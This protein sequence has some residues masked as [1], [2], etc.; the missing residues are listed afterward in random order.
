MNMSARRIRILISSP[1]DVADEREKAKRVIAV[2][3]KRFAGRLRIEAILW[4]DLPLP[5]T[6]S[7]QEGIDVVLDDEEGI[8]VAIF[9]LWSRL[10]TPLGPKI[11]KPDD[12]QEY[13]SGTEREFDLMI[14]AFD[15]SGRQ[16][17]EVFAYV[18]Q[19]QT[20]FHNNLIGKDDDEIRQMLD[21]REL[22]K[23]FIA[24]R[25]HDPERGH[26]LS[27]YKTFPRPNDFAEKLKS[28]LKQVLDDFTENASVK[29]WEGSPF[30]GLEL[31]EE[32]HE[33]IFFGRD[34]AVCNLRLKLHEAEE[35]G[36]AFVLIVGGSGTGKSSLVRA[37]LIPSV[38]SQ[39]IDTERE[40]RTAV[41]LPSRCS[42]RPCAGL[43]SLLNSPSVLPELNLPQ[44]KLDLLVDTLETDPESVVQR[45]LDSA[46]ARASEEAGKEICLLLIVDQLEELFSHDAI[47]QMDR[48]RFLRTIRALAQSGRF[49]I[50]ATIRSDY[51]AQVLAEP[52]L[53]ELKN[54]SG[55]AIG[56]FELFPPTAAE[57]RSIITKPAELAGLTFEEDSQTGKRLDEMILEA[58][59][60]TPEAMPMLE[61]LLQ[62]LYERRSEDDVLRIDAYEE[63]GGLEGAI[64]SH[65]ESIYRQLPEEVQRI[66]PRVLS[67]LVSLAGKDTATLVRRNAERNHFS[68]EPHALTLINTFIEERLIV[69]DSG[70]VKVVHEALLRN[71]DRVRAWADEN[72]D[73]V[74]IQDRVTR[75]EKE[76]RS[77]DRSTDYFLPSGKPTADGE[78]LLAKEEFS[79]S[80]SVR[81][82]IELSS[83]YHHERSRRKLRIFQWTSI[84]FFIV[85]VLAI[86]GLFEAGRQEENARKQTSI[87]VRQSEEAEEQREI[88]VTAAGDARAAELEMET[89]LRLAENHLGKV[90]AEKA[91]S[92]ALAK[93]HNSAHLY[94][95]LA[96]SKLDREKEYETIQAVADLAMYEPIFERVTP[97]IRHKES[98]ADIAFSPDGRSLFSATRENTIHVVDLLTGQSVGE[99]KGHRDAVN[100]L[101]VSPD[102]TKLVSGSDDKEVRIWDIPN[103]RELLSL[104][105]HK[106]GVL[107][108]AFSP[109]EKVLASASDGG[110]ALAGA[111]IRLWNARTGESIA[112]LEGHQGG[113]TSIAFSPDGKTLISGSWDK[114]VRVW[115]LD[116]GEQKAELSVDGGEVMSVAYSPNGGILVA[117][118]DSILSMDTGDRIHL[119]DA[120]TLK[121]TVSLGEGTSGVTSLAFSPDEQFLLSGH[122][123]GYRGSDNSLRIWNVESGELFAVLE[124]HTNSI[125][126]VAFSPNGSTIASGSWDNTIQ[127]WDNTANRSELLWSTQTRCYQD[128]DFSPNGQWIVASSE[129]QVSFQVFDSVSGKLR[130]EFDGHSDGVTSV[131]YSPDGDQIASGSLDKTVRI[132]DAASGREERRIE[133]H[134]GHINSVCFSPDGRTVA[135]AS[136]DYYNQLKDATIRIWD[137]DSGDELFVLEGH[138]SDVSSIDFCPD[139]SRIVSGGASTYPNPTDNTIRIW[140]LR[141]PVSPLIVD[142]HSGTVKDVRYSPSGTK[143][144]SCS[145][146]DTVRLFDAETGTEVAMIGEENARVSDATF[147]PDG[148]TVIVGWNGMV[149]ILE[150]DSLHLKGTIAENMFTRTRVDSVAISPHG[151]TIA[152]GS[153]DDRLRL[154][155]YNL[156]LDKTPTTSEVEERIA[157]F[158]MALEDVNLVPLGG[159]FEESIQDQSTAFTWSI[160]HPFHWLQAA[161]TGDSKA[162]VELGLCYEKLGNRAQAELWYKRA[163]DSG[164]R[165]GRERL[166]LLDKATQ[167]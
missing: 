122:G 76:W 70:Q 164:D 82:Y 155:R 167:D 39:N 154:W 62:Q 102:G 40:W 37:G 46:L 23:A 165:Y 56:Q 107:A 42:E 85:T 12:G 113:V 28:D 123:G 71:W 159:E 105:G 153:I 5:A 81:Q 114:T 10:G 14:R 9:I 87:A 96:L 68:N 142:A 8:D 51:Y 108:V 57:L 24:E 150:A 128:V 103:Q 161:E 33:T 158:G 83:K 31:F 115:D 34:E 60:D 134:S 93:S 15:Q 27:A 143:I 49:W 65:A 125:E 66:L 44:Q 156:F 17:P 99:F 6:A 25:F 157:D 110:V 74:Q 77:E 89:Q 100:A 7:F 136:R 133:G 94:A 80:S 18:R 151:D 118:T 166:S 119:W 92:S 50:V 129:T 4:E 38:L 36:S 1:G 132:W 29:S 72:R 124:G 126:C 131:C 59:N 127:L 61:F 95:L 19:D 78:A 45:E 88:A 145:W 144:I 98:V 22:L 58:S 11:L 3:Q 2:L 16:R 147:S 55:Q 139:G 79:V 20:E 75:A 63:L 106:A 112:V 111:R 162:M 137:L 120:R 163:A 138:V 69:A 47:T 21:Q 90:F 67:Q 104:S 160:S 54:L 149:K 130:L 64:G 116:S 13:Q 91:Q 141:D 84:S 140:D 146:D 121:K 73:F 86:Y 135:S 35:R 32:Q 97:P 101:D 43:L 52:S 41:F 48:N 148:K 53:V 26:N 109:D 152:A 117:G 30:R